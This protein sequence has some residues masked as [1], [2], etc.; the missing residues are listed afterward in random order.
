MSIIYP[1]EC[2]LTEIGKQKY[3]YLNFELLSMSSSTYSI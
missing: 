1:T 2:S 3:E